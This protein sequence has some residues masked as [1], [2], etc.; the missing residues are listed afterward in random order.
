[1]PLCLQ[2]LPATW[3]LD[4]CSNSAAVIVSFSSFTSFTSQALF[5]PQNTAL[6]LSQEFRNLLDLVTDHLALSSCSCLPLSP[7]VYWSWWV[8]ATS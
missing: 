6:T 7:P 5:C 8:L 1:M 2:S 4:L 3:Q